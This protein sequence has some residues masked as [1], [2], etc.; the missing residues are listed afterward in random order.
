MQVSI[1]T[2]H[3]EADEQMKI[4]LN[5]KLEKLQKYFSKIVSVRAILIKENYRYIAEVTLSAKNM[6]LAAKEEAEDI[7]SAVDLVLHKLEK[8][9]LKTRD[10]VKEHKGRKLA[11]NMKD[12]VE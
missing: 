7:H 6:Q 9:L 8:Q 4:Y 10:K 12:E 5:E 3:F 1:T 11:E 2:R